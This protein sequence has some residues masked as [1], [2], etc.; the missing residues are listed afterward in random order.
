M[1]QNYELFNNIYI[2][3]DISYEIV[4]KVKVLE[5]QKVVQIQGE[6]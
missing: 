5:Y 6:L 1:I 2:F 3:R 4:L